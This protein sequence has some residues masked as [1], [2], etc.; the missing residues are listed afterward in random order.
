MKM[1]PVRPMAS[2]T[3]E[4]VA[5]RRNGLTNASRSSKMSLG[6][7]RRP[8]KRHSKLNALN[9]ERLGLSSALKKRRSE[10]LN[11]NRKP[12]GSP[13]RRD[14]S[15]KVRWCDS[16]FGHEASNGSRHHRF[17]RRKSRTNTRRASSSKDHPR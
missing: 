12:N 17:S 13:I 14:V 7:T 3:P 5:N 2:V 16:P 8:L 9:G 15:R 4:E 10:K 6:L 11:S 1:L